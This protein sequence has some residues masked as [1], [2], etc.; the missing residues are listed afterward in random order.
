M[1]NSIYSGAFGLPMDQPL[2]R[3]SGGGRDPEGELERGADATIQNKFLNG[4]ID[5]Y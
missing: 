5:I 3:F 4:L 2:Y 1:R